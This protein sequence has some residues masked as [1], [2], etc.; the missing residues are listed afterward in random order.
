MRCQTTERDLVGALGDDPVADPVEDLRRDRLL[1]GE[2]LRH[3]RGAAL[4]VPAELDD[5]GRRPCIRSAS[6][7]IRRCA[8][9]ARSASRIGGAEEQLPRLEVVDDVH[10][11]QDDAGDAAVAHRLGGRRRRGGT[12]RGGRPARPPP[13]PPGSRTRCG[14]T[15]RP[16]RGCSG[17]AARPRVV[18]VEEVEARGSGSTSSGSVKSSRRQSMTDPPRRSRRSTSSSATPIRS[19]GLSGAPAVE[20]FASG[21]TART[22]RR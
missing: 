17:A 3:E 2:E 18:E 8:R 6:A 15:R 7:M 11:L 9:S 16:G 21:V 5:G 20:S 12:G 1:L 14:G 19:R 4:H 13:A 22:W 10:H